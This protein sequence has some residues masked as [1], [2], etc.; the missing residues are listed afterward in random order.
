MKL[1][2]FRSSRPTQDDPT[3]AN[4]ERA[5]LYHNATKHHYS[6]FATSLGYL[7]WNTQPDPFRRFAGAPLIQ[8]PLTNEDRTP[9]FEDVYYPHLIPPLPVTFASIGS[10]FE[11]S[12][13]LSAWKEFRGN[14]WALRVNPSSGN[15]HPTEGYAILPPCANIHS[16]AGVYHY[17]P[18]EHGLERRTVISD[19]VWGQLIQGFPVETFFVGLTSIFWREAWKYGERSFRYCQIDLGHALAALSYAAAIQGWKAIFLSGVTDRQ[20]AALLG[21]DRTSEFPAAEGEHPEALVA[22]V[23]NTAGLAE[24]PAQL[25]EAVLATIAQGTWSGTANQLSSDHVAWPIL[26]AVATATEYPEPADNPQG[27]PT[28]LKFPLRPAGTPHTARKLLLRRRSAVTFDGRTSLSTQAFFTMLGRTIPMLD[29][30][31]WDTFG[32]QAQVHLVLFVHRVRGLA[33]GIY[34]LVRNYKHTAELKG[35]LKQDFVWKK[36]TGGPPEMELYLLEA[37]EFTYQAAEVSC[38]QNIAGA[39]AFSLGM[40]ARFEPLLREQGAWMYRR[41]FWETG[42]I[43]QILYLEAEAAGVRGTGIGCFFDDPVH[44]MLGLTD[45]TYQSLYHFTVGGPVDDPR[46]TT[47]APYTNERRRVIR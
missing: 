8:L 39:G 28:G 44:E 45:Q 5:I 26:E 40:L 20:L 16:Q 18:N 24:L 1:S 42:L 10:F 14:R 37:G 36:P 34:L 12:L 29:T 19:E 11:L 30:V 43:G 27:A 32:G 33:P 2:G 46:L 4:W 47:L 9:G 41:L 22:I 6:R 25:P 31:P 3:R 17:A 38:R 7:D 23:P 21:V 15:L 35:L 13:A